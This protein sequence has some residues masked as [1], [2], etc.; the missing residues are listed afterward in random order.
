MH[1]LHDDVVEIYPI[2]PCFRSATATGLDPKSPVRP[3]EDALCH[4]DVD[5]TTGRFRAHRHTAVSSFEERVPNREV[6]RDLMMVLTHIVLSGLQ[7]DTV[8]SDR[9][10]RTEDQDIITALRIEA[11]CI[12]RIGWVPNRDVVYADMIGIVRMHRPARGIL[13]RDGLKTYM[14]AAIQEDGVRTPCGSHHLRILPPVTLGTA[15]IDVTTTDDVEVLCTDRRNE[16]GEGSLRVSFP[17]RE[18]ILV[19]SIRRLRHT[20]HEWIVIP[21]RIPLQHGPLIEP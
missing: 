9:D 17:A 13:Y 6:I 18:I 15:T 2:I 12:R 4:L 1:V 21:V 8:I 19:C 10:F 7:G 20:R 16:G 3:I 5:H 11:V 14:T